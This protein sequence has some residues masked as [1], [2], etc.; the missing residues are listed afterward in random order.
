MI[1]N[2][3]LHIGTR[4]AINLIDNFRFNSL[5]YKNPGS[6]RL[7]LWLATSYRRGSQNVFKI[8]IGPDF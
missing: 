1:E 7:R 2:I 5:I 8:Y 6:G 3:A 4:I